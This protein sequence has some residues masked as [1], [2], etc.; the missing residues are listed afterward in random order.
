[1]SKYV[2]KNSKGRFYTAGRQY[3]GETYAS[4]F[5]IALEYRNEVGVFPRPN[6]L[7]EMACVSFKVAK[8]AI[9]FISGENE[10][11]HKPSGHGYSGRG[12]MKLSMTDQFFLL[13]LYSQDP[14]RPLYSY[15]HELYS[16][17][18]TKVS[19]STISA[20]FHSSFEYSAKCR[21]PSI[22]APVSP[23]TMTTLSQ[24]DLQTH[25]LSFSSN[26]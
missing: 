6:R 21:K 14:S 3:S 17:S 4:I 11:L 5:K 12:S 22:F 25:K 2:K 7:S 9:M 8:K 26:F 13:G 19:K 18:G 10:L 16:F 23:V 15:V 24:T 1:M 20:W